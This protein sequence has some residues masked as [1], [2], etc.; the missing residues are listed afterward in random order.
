M[1]GGIQIK[2]LMFAIIAA[3]LSNIKINKI[4]RSIHK[5]KPIKGRFEKI[6][7]LKNNASVILDYAHTPNALETAMLN[8][9]EEFPLSKIS[10][11]FGCGGNRDKDK[12]PI[13]GSIAKKYCE[14]IYLTDD[15]PR[16]ENPKLIRDQIKKDCIIK[17][18]MK[19]HQDLKLFSTLLIDYPL[20]M[21]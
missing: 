4:V 7:Y 5:I 8:L 2:N 10:L 6:G 16:S 20:E 1:I 21:F 13:M 18:F 3:Y 19:F 15:N 14:N 17:K 12:R 9:K 11:V